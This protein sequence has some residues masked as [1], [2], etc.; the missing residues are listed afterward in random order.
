[1]SRSNRFVLCLCLAVLMATWWFAT[2]AEGG[3]VMP[4]MGGGQ[5]TEAMKHADILFDGTTISVVVDSTVATPNLV[6]L[7]P[8]DA[9]DPAR[10]WSV[11]GAMAY[12]YQHAWNPGGF[13]TRPVVGGVTGEFWVERISYDPGLLTYMRPPQWTTSMGPTWTQI[14]V[15]DGDRWKWSGSMQ[16]NAYA[17]QD[18][19]LSTYTAEYRVYIGDPVTGNPW[20]GFNSATVTLTWNA[21][22]EPATLAL[23][24]LGAMALRLP[25]RKR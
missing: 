25:R 1:M 15:A 16:H 2:A 6:A 21:S 14:F 9:F 23:V 18:P 10:P 7:T 3:I 22:P 12:N 13:I 8:P 20:S 5:S 19:T 24:G 17:V 11:L 4:K